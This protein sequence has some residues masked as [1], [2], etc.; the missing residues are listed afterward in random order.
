MRIWNAFTF[1]VLC[2]S[3]A[4]L[5]LSSIGLNIG[6]FSIV[7]VFVGAALGLVTFRRRR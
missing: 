2:G 5:A 6:P 7:A 1:G 3:L 4:L